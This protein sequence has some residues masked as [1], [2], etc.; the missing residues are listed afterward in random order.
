[1]PYLIKLDPQ[2][3]YIQFTGSASGEEVKESSK[4]IRD[5]QNGRSLNYLIVDFNDCSEC[6][7]SKYDALLVAA[8]D[9]WLWQ[10]N[11]SFKIAI[12]ATDEHILKLVK[13]YRDSPLMVRAEIFNRLTD[14]YKW[15]IV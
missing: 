8:Y 9:H 12:V 5:M 1:M 3:A 7:V 14:A 6:Q 15:A 10:S 2:G 13:V 11:S 4:L